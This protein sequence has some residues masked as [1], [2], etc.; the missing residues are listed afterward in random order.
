MSYGAFYGFTE[1]VEKALQAD[2]LPASERGTG[3]GSLQTALGLAALP[4]SLSM[5]MVMTHYGSMAAF[6]AA[7]SLAALGSLLLGLWALKQR[8][9]STVVPG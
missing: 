6:T 8:R 4:S 1:G 3:Y 9:Q 7:G 5:G 2:L